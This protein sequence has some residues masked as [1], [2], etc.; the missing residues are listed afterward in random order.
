MTAENTGA[1]EGNNKGR[2]E[3]NPVDPK[4]F[5]Q[6]D[7]SRVSNEDDVKLTQAEISSWN[8]LIDDENSPTPSAL[9]VLKE[10]NLDLV[11]VMS[12]T[13]KYPGT[14]DDREEAS[15]AIKAEKQGILDNLQKEFTEMQEFVRSGPTE[16][17]QSGVSYSEYA[18]NLIYEL[19][20]VR[21]AALNHETVDAGLRLINYGK[22]RFRVEELI[23]D[24]GD[25]DELP[26]LLTDVCG[27]VLEGEARRMRKVVKGA[28]SDYD[29]EQIAA[30]LAEAVKL[31]GV[32]A[33]KLDS[34]DR[35][36]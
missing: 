15:S 11:R 26:S 18:T 1:D 21:V 5:D 34:T 32:I 7:L 27:L 22:L 17:D 12:Q 16:A 9:E 24:A 23:D 6:A 3:L 2:F 30:N 36:V 33:T 13:I 25:D 8:S 20:T 14:R 10:H 28:Y 35:D 29:T 31:L 4:S 19:A